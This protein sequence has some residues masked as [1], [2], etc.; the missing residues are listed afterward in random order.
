LVFGFVLSLIIK[1][2]YVGFFVGLRRPYLWA[3]LLG[4]LAIVWFA[5]AS[6]FTSVSVA[7]WAATF[8]L[9][10]SIRTRTANIPDSETSEFFDAVTG[11]AN[12]LLKRRL[13]LF[14]FVAGCLIGWVAFYGQACDHRGT[15]QSLLSLGWNAL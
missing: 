13:G 10:F 8:A 6:V 15:C 5:A 9:L 7:A 3:T 14:A 12:T 11:V 4:V 2:S 1:A